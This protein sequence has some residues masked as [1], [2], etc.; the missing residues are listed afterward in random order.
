MIV[1]G[2][3]ALAGQLIGVFGERGRAAAADLEA[4]RVAMDRTW[5]DEFIVL[6]WFGPTL[7]SWFGYTTAIDEQ[8]RSI[9]NAPELTGIQVAI[10]A[11]VFG[12]G[13]LKIK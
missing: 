1:K 9:A 2:A 3:L 10:T 12:L 7:L 5:T 11:A 6:F 4:R 13:K 8:I